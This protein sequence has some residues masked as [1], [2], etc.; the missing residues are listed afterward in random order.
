MT[1]IPSSN[2]QQ[3]RDVDMA[4]ALFLGRFQP[5]HTGHLLTI[6]KLSQ[7]Y[8]RVIVGITEAEPSVMT[9][10][11]VIEILKALLPDEGFEFIHVKGSVEGGT[12]VI[13]CEF[14]VCCSG[15][16]N[17]LTKMA[18]KGYRTEYIERAMDDLY[19]GTRQRSE[20]VDRVI[21]NRDEEKGAS[22]TEFRLI[23]T[24]ILRPIEKINPLHFAGIEADVLACG[25][26]KKPL[27]VDR[28]SMAVL[29]GSHRYALLVKLGCQFA[30][31]VLCDYDDESIFV[32]N[33]L[34]HRFNF[35]ERKWISKQHV[36]AS[37][38][39]GNLY[40]PRT[41]RHFFPFRKSDHPIELKSLETGVEQS[42]E[43]L[44][45]VV[46][47]NQEIRKNEEYINELHYELSTLKGYIEE[48]GQV[49]KWLKNQNEYIRSAEESAPRKIQT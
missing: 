47:R 4:T 48:Q 17:V 18:E 24:R 28:L 33:H 3:A 16:P 14:D 31:V 30:P 6:R 19:S 13:D 43:H 27:I 23:E 41:T 1:S 2:K 22:L 25:V 11:S 29:D 5:P 44:I 42:I 40:D 37:A 12:A 8:A 34:S 10:P 9:V 38:I 15:N 26:M 35:D 36:R 7:Y 39:S 32:G 21:S 45:A 20:Y 46:D 49:L